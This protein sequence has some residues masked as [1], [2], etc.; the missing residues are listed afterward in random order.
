MPTYEF[1][2]ESCG[3]DY[4]V[5]T[6]VEDRNN[7]IPC[8]TCGHSLSR[9]YRTAPANACYGCPSYELRR[10]GSEQ[11]AR[12]A[13]DRKFQDQNNDEI[14]YAAAHTWK[15]VPEAQLAREAEHMASIGG[16]GPMQNAHIKEVGN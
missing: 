15:P 4:E 12:K 6:R 9:V 16:P 5:I 7:P 3:K 14:A 10:G 11:V 13:A 1:A 2:C 8:P